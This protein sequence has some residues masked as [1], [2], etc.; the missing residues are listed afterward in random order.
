MITEKME[1]QAEIVSLEIFQQHL[2][3]PDQDL[4]LELWR[5]TNSFHDFRSLPPELR[6]MVWRF[7]FREHG[8]TEIIDPIIEL[9]DYNR[10][11]HSIRHRNEDP[12]PV[13]LYINR[14]SRAEALRRY[15]VFHRQPP[16]GLTRLLKPLFFDPELDTLSIHTDYIFEG[17]NP[18]RIEKRQHF[19][20]LISELS[21]QFPAHMKKVKYIDMCFDYFCSYYKPSIRRTMFNRNSPAG[22]IVEGKSSFYSAFLFHFPGL[23]EVGLFYRNCTHRIGHHFIDISN[24]VEAFLKDN[25]QKF[26]SGRAPGIVLLHL[27]GVTYTS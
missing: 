25:E 14:E 24:N 7:T 13:S 17:C 3:D 27:E 5:N 11:S 10:R 23:C 22:D 16:P 8:R 19:K 4:F 12:L 26:D 9:T 18:A 2:P 15:C 20:T 1:R 21:L 6:C